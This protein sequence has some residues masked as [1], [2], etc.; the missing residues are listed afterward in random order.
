MIGGE[1]VVWAQGPE[2]IGGYP[3]ERH[4]AG[5]CRMAVQESHRSFGLMNDPEALDELTSHPT[6]DGEAL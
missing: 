3:P 1:T 4:F 5:L 2:R 6:A